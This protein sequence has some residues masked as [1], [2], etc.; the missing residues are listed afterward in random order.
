MCLNIIYSVLKYSY[1]NEKWCLLHIPYFLLNISYDVLRR[2]PGGLKWIFPK[3]LFWLMPKQLNIFHVNDWA[4]SWRLVSSSFN[5][6][7]NDISRM[8]WN[9]S[10]V[11]I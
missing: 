9:K 8:Q 10:Y 6:Y 4:S 3:D 2:S 7:M 11:K 5:L 1:Q